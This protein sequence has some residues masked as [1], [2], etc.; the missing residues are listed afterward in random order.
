[1]TRRND[2][3]SGPTR[4]TVLKW[5]GACVACLAPVFGLPRTARA[6]AGAE[7][8]VRTKVS[9]FFTPL[10]SGEIRCDL[11]PKGC[12]IPEGKRGLCRVRE[13]RKGQCTSLVFGN[14]CTFQLDPIEKNPFFHV[15]P[16][17]RSLSLSTAGCNFACKFCQSW[18]MAL[19]GP[20]EVYAYDIPPATVVKKAGEMKARS[21]AYTFG[22]P[23]VFYE[24]MDAVGLLARKAGFRN[25]IHSNGFI[26]KAP[27]EKLCKG[28]D[29]ANIDLK[30][31]S[32]T[33][34][35]KLCGGELDPVLETLKTLH[36][37]KVH[38]EI[39]NLLIPTM[40]DDMSVVR[41]MCLWV[42][43]ELG[44][45]TPLHFSRFYPL[46]KLAN[47]PPTPVATLVK[48]RSVARDTGLEYVYLDNVPGHEG[49]NTFCPACKK[50]I[51]RRMGFMVGE[52]RLKSGKC[53]FC[54]KPI[55]GIWA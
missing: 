3:E 20:E 6:Q 49:G 42:K 30:G 37:A 11:C 50:K 23:V 16:G 45:S 46:Y 12:R 32:P 2:A 53:G 19:V 14:P 1:M 51:I 41:D 7:G 27:L 44:S 31:F 28:L 24:Y 48:A 29:A 4:R 52:V 55:P 35:R 38:L 40:N 43:K 10:E 26:Q 36:R 13:N 54:G 39:T 33:F 22:E 47:L 5:C 8:L 18:E 25:L 17:T 21:V 34:Y 9:P 15:L